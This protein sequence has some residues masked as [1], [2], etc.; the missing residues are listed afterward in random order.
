VY[1]VGLHMYYRMT[2]VNLI[3]ER[4]IQGTGTLTHILSG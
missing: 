4:Y 2:S 1:L 3:R